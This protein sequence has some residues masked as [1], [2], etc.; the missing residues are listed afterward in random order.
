[1]GRVALLTQP[2]QSRTMDAALLRLCVTDL[3]ASR[4]LE[5]APH[6]TAAMAEFAIDTP[7]RQAA[8]LAQVGHES[9]SFAKL[10]ESLNYSV[11]GLR[12]TF[13]ARVAQVQAQALGRKPGESVVPVER[14]VQI[15]Q[16]AYGGRM[17]NS[18]PT[19]GFRYR[20]RGGIQ[21]TG[22]DNYRECG[23]ALG[24]DLVNAPELLQVLP[25]AIRSAG[26]FWST[27]GCSALADSGDFVGLT[28]RINGA[29]KGLD[30]RQ[31]R[32]YVAKRALGV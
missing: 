11:D 6:V 3:A 8:F 7:V 15:A 17:G 9:S 20:G 1:M 19:D 26:W 4:A 32:W 27:H 30:D 25:G 13:P 29:T 23:A 2:W 16:L 12:A 28:R 24:L 10:V 5:W 14:Q 31:A 21:I 22:K 18:A